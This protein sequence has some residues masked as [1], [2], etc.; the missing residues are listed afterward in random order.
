MGRFVSVRFV[1]VW[2]EVV[3]LDGSLRC[4]PRLLLITESGPLSHH[5]D[6][7]SKYDLDTKNISKLWC[8]LPWLGTYICGLGFS[9]QNRMFLELV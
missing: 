6:Y 8:V 4:D 9:W 1:S 5:I 7:N 3:P 2:L